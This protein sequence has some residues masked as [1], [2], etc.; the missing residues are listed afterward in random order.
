MKIKIDKSSKMELEHTNPINEIVLESNHNH[1]ELL[2]W[3]IVK[4][5]FKNES[6]K[7]FFEDVVIA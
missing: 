2:F 5:D 7:L 1:V 6:Y 3:K 4:I